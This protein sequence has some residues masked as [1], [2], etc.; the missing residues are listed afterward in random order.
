VQIKEFH[1]PLEV[2]WLEGRKVVAR[3][4]GKRGVEISPPPVFKGTEPDLWS[5]EDFLVA[6]AASCLAVTL[7]GFAQR[8]GLVLHRLKVGADGVAGLREDGHFGFRRL[9]LRLAITTEPGQEALALE[10]A[11]RAEDAC[12]VTASLDLPSTLEVEVA[13]EAVPEP[14]GEPI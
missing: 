2:D 5:P 9:E 6:S 14:V 11:H 1:F 7:T 12:L 4:D 13:A 10:L 8:E 3:V